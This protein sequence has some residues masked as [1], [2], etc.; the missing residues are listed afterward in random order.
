MIETD[1]NIYVIILVFGCLP[2][3]IWRFLGVFFA[4]R[5]SED[6]EVFMWVRAVATALIAALVMH[7]VIAPTGL[8]AQ[9]ALSSRVIALSAAVVMYAIMRPR[10]S[11][12]LAT[13]LVTLYIL[14][15]T[16][17]ELF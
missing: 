12:S 14:E 4:E 8:L 7:I 10:F 11:Y 2:T 17:I 16:G 15:A 6:S 3:V 9:T 5:I 1:F 13:S